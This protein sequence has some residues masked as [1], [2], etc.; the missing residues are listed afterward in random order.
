M[1]NTGASLFQANSVAPIQWTRQDDVCKLKLRNEA[2]VLPGQNR[3]LYKYHSFRKPII[4]VLLI[5]QQSICNLFNFLFLFIK[6][7]PKKSLNLI[8]YKYAF[9]LISGWDLKRKKNC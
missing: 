4:T 1:E 9:T 7:F 6:K 3:Q 5:F 8:I 2:I